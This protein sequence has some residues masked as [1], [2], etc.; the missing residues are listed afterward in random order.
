M[1]KSLSDIITDTVTLFQFLYI[2][3]TM[4]GNVQS[5]AKINILLLKTPQY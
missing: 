3:N 5:S 1:Y 2:T 4:L